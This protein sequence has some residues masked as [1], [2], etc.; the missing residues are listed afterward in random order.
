MFSIEDLRCIFRFIQ[1][2]SK[3]SLGEASP[4]M[5]STKTKKMQKKYKY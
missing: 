1:L 2:E 3:D 5:W 4:H